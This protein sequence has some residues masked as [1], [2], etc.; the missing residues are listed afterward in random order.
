MIYSLKRNLISIILILAFYNQITLAKSEETK[1]EKRYLVKNYINDAREL[2]P[3]KSRL[4]IK[5]QQQINNTIKEQAIEKKEQKK[6]VKKKQTS[7]LK[8]KNQSKNK[9]NLK[10]ITI[11]YLP[12]EEKPDNNELNVLKRAIWKFSK[13]NNLTI[14]GY[15]E[16]REGD[17]TSKVRRLSLKR[18]LFL[19]EIFLKN[20]FQSIK[21]HVKAMGNDINILGDKDIVIIST[22]LKQ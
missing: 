5:K 21:I 2:G 6:Q 3:P 17:S 15:A 20:N 19:R 10:K 12:D 9:N 22:K 7:V 11:K 18:A 1:S 4:I 8:K 13:L 14:Q 16:K